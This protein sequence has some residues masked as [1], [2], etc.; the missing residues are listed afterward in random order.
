MECPLDAR[1]FP[2][3]TVEQ[4]TRNILMETSS[5][6]N[7]PTLMTIQDPVEISA[8]RI[9][10]GEVPAVLLLPKA[11]DE[12]IMEDT[13][14]DIFGA[15]SY[16]QPMVYPILPEDCLIFPGS[17][18]PP[19]RGHMAL[20]EAAVTAVQK[21]WPNTNATTNATSPSSCPAP[22]IVFELS[23]VNA[24]KP[25]M[26]PEE[27]ARRVALFRQVVVW[28]NTMPPCSWGILLT[29]A[30]LFADKVHVL[31]Q[32]APPNKLSTTSSTASSAFSHMMPPTNRRWS[33]VIGTDTLVRILNPKYY[34]DDKHEMMHSLRGMEVNFV[35]G[36]RVEQ[37]KTAGG[38]ESAQFVTGQKELEGLPSDMKEIFL[39]LDESDFRVDVSSTELRA[40]ESSKKMDDNDD[41]NDHHGD[42][43]TNP[44]TAT[45]K[46]QSG[47]G[48]GASSSLGAIG[49]ILNIIASFAL[50]VAVIPA[51]GLSTCEA[52][53]A[54]VPLVNTRY[55]I[56][57]GNGDLSVTMNSSLIGLSPFW[58]PRNLGMKTLNQASTMETT[59]SASISGENQEVC[60]PI[61]KCQQC[62]F[63]EQKEY[64]ACKETGRWAKFECSLPTELTSS[65]RMEMM[66]CKY[67]EADEEFAMVRLQMMCFLIGSIA[68]MSVRKQKR[69]SASLFDQRK[70]GG[71]P[72]NGAPGR[73][74]SMFETANDEQI[75]FTPMTNQEREK[76]P[77]MQFTED[78]LE[79]V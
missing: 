67:T 73:K 79:V 59:F 26:D 5:H 78:S 66:S 29:S 4:S 46:N 30:P 50:I 21:K 23:I 42:Q 6:E 10:L 49:P 34:H 12:G 22:T 58:D 39:L 69:L 71:E 35:V 76:V 55:M 44:I 47:R 1:D 15:N 57:G 9:L 54:T 19:H 52:A 43:G 13:T 53:S 45:T 3:V 17:F 2:G 70:Q 41:D 48:R 31:R 75:E 18:N 40:Q 28:N 27:V 62:T 77:L 64:E 36:G 8:R 25:P 65:T 72:M 14:S 51:M 38:G 37:S 56:L 11:V 7:E 32:A 74:N 24:D 20:A 60:T 33:F 16:L 63:S 68:V 61:E